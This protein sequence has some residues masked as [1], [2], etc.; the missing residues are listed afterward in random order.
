MK[1]K[2][3]LYT[4]IVLFLL[5]CYFPLFLHLD[6][7][8]LRLWDEARRGVN[9]LEMAESGNWLVTHF[10]GQPE[11]YGTK[12]PLLVWS[13]AFFMKLFGYGE[14]AVRLPSALAGLATVLLLLIFHQKVLKIPL[15]GYLSGIVLIT[16][17]VYID[18]HGAIAGD[19]DAL[20][21]LWC[22]AYLFC[23]YHFLES[24]KLKYLYLTGVF[25]ILAGL[26]KG[27]AAFFFVP[28]MFI[29]MLWQRK[30]KA[31]F[32]SKHTYF[33]LLMTVVGILSFYILREIYNPGYLKAVWDNELWGR[34]FKS[35]EGHQ[36]K[37]YFY[38][39][40]IYKYEKFHPWLYF[41]PLGIYLV[42]KD[43]KLK[44]FGQYALINL[45]FFFFVISYSNT[46]LEWYILPSLPLLSSLV[47]IAL[48]KLLEG[49]ENI[50]SVQTQLSKA[51][52]LG[53]FSIAFFL[54]PYLTIIKKVYVFEH[55]GW[56]RATMYYRDFMKQVQDF[57]GYTILHP[58][59]SG[60]IVFYKSVYNLNG[61]QIQEKVLH[62]PPP[63]VQAA[64]HNSAPIS[65][66]THV[67]VC[68]KEA[69]NYVQKHFS[70]EEIRS[71]RDCKFL[72]IAQQL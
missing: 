20:L 35:N 37:W 54:L 18:S 48:T 13:Q 55:K 26:T 27:I 68:E 52:L 61:Y 33:V 53:I 59:Y 19:F 39:R 15:S 64:E 65:T 29:Y 21:T 32:S 9:A 63:V 51:V 25:L 44:K 2:I 1:A 57:K 58:H 10:E 31:L 67:M 34:Y 22:T 30:A 62:S 16:S 70:F 50:L 72:L 11:M 6:S 66:G 4:G 3:Y 47:G 36:W 43:P 38:F 60:H 46:K 24:Q 71:W 7:L 14:L 17:S 56:D 69:L 5:I 40:I 49:L 12:P 23:F 42:L 28:A 45:A 8:S 41:I